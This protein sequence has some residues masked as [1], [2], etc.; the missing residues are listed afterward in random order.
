M[1]V[2]PKIELSEQERATLVKW[3]RGRST[4]VRKMQRAQIGG[5]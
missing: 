4:G 1:R 5:G 2:A 3:S